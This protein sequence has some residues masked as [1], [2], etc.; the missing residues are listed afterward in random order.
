MKCLF[1]LDPENILTELK[2]SSRFSVTII[3]LIEGILKKSE[4]IQYSRCKDY[5]N[6]WKS[7]SNN[8]SNAKNAAQHSYSPLNKYLDELSE[9]ASWTLDLLGISSSLSS[10]ETLEK[11]INQKVRE[12]VR[13]DVNYLNKLLKRGILSKKLQQMISSLINT[14][15]EDFT[16]INIILTKIN[17]RFKT[18]ESL[19]CLNHALVIIRTSTNENL[20]THVIKSI[21]LLK[22]NTIKIDSSTSPIVTIG[23]M[24]V[25]L[26]VKILKKALLYIK[27]EENQHPIRFH[28]IDKHSNIISAVLPDSMNE[29]IYDYAAELQENSSSF[30]GINIQQWFKELFAYHRTFVF[31]NDIS[32]WVKQAN[33]YL[34]KLNFWIE[35][36]SKLSNREELEEVRRMITETFLEWNKHEGSHTQKTNKI[37]GVEITQWVNCLV[38]IIPNESGKKIVFDFSKIKN[39]FKSRQ[40]LSQGRD[41]FLS[42]LDPRVSGSNLS[43]P[44]RWEGIIYDRLGK[45]DG[46]HSNKHV[47]RV[48]S[49]VK[50]QEKVLKRIILQRLEKVGQRNIQN[51]T[52]I[53]LHNPELE[54]IWKEAGYKTPNDLLKSFVKDDF[55]PLLQLKRIKVKF[56]AVDAQKI[57]QTAYNQFKHGE[58][59]LTS[60]L[61]YFCNK[62]LIDAATT[63]PKIT[64]RS[65]DN[66]VAFKHLNEITKIELPLPRFS[67]SKGVVYPELTNEKEN[68]AAIRVFLDIL[69]NS[70][71]GKLILKETGFINKFNKST[72][73]KTDWRSGVN[74]ASLTG[75][76]TGL[77]DGIVSVK[78]G[79]RYVNEFIIEM[80][81]TNKANE[82]LSD[83]IDKGPFSSAL[84]D[85]LRI[86]CYE[87]AGKPGMVVHPSFDKIGSLIYTIMKFDR[88]V[89]KVLSQKGAYLAVD[90]NRKSVKG[91]LQNNPSTLM[92]QFE[93]IFNITKNMNL[94]ID[95]QRF[96]V[97]SECEK[98]VFTLFRELVEIILK[99]K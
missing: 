40:A 59:N 21:A 66:G 67:K 8:L 90:M 45:P 91:V 75:Q 32:G 3:K 10:S 55:N 17:K 84:G 48:R 56:K 42:R 46:Y 53:F 88:G 99:V 43:V 14:E 63:Q 29:A 20:R 58:S 51:L 50:G 35:L 62:N 33:S 92:E 61:T 79:N 57:L 49:A 81:G 28:S 85:I 5:V 37:R 41:V 2:E 19:I 44:D 74:T 97:D 54:A 95:L 6:F 86:A 31:T 22:P 18:Y 77:L 34:K 52:E 71:E 76:I 94:G 26:D 70:K 30:D 9:L 60:F 69:T 24:I 39:R 83:L 68:S 96:S 47:F 98:D 89:G 4:N 12:F 87:A 13:G 65:I 23:D 72:R 93:K 38:E 25:D 78:Q 1:W 73:F 16:N 36:E 7:F 11:K 64:S 15:F 27:K 80:I 82:T